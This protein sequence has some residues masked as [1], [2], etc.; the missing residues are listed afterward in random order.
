MKIS[1]LSLEMIVTLIIGVAVITGCFYAAGWLG[2]HSFMEWY[3]VRDVK[4]LITCITV[5]PFVGFMA[6]AIFNALRRRKGV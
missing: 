4:S 3:Y 1:A 6:Y 5:T 2:Y